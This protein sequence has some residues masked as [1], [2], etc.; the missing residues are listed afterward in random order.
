MHHQVPFCGLAPAVD[1]PLPNPGYASH[2]PPGATV[3]MSQ[4]VLRSHGEMLRGMRT[5]GPPPGLGPSMLAPTGIAPTGEF[6]LLRPL[7]SHLHPHLQLHL[8]PHHHP[9]LH[10]P[11]P[12][13]PSIPSMLGPSGAQRP[14][15]PVI[16]TC[17]NMQLHACAACSHVHPAY[18]CVCTQRLGAIA[19][20]TPIPTTPSTLHPHPLPHHHPLPHSLPHHHPHPQPN[21]SLSS[22]WRRADRT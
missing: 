7:R 9:H 5:T 21:P 10:R 13:A 20:P 8:Y 22:L 3:D 15:Q 4:P 6:G 2:L 17:T 11:S 16:T 12:S 14:S 1:P 19:L 18:T